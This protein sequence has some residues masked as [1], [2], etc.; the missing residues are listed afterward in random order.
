MAK[1]KVANGTH[2]EGGVSYGKDAIV[3]SNKDL[4]K[5]F[6]G[7]FKKVEYEPRPEAEQEEQEP[8]SAPE[9]K[10]VRPTTAPAAA[11]PTT[12]PG[13]AKPAAKRTRAKG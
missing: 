9:P 1:F 11:K 5:A 4:A 8:V 3:E 6:P 13:A 12:V 10:V 7:K 2:L